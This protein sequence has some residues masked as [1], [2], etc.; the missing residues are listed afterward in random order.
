M[1]NSGRLLAGTITIVVGGAL[2][3]YDIYQLAEGIK[4]FAQ[5]GPE[6]AADIRQ[7]ANELEGQLELLTKK[8]SDPS[9]PTEET[10]A[11]LKIT[12]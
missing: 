1:A 10:M 2:M 12:E 7:I 3:A 11:S 4:G 5:M 8:P 9:L 6:G